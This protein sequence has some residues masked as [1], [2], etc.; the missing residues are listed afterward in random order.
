M[1]WSPSSSARRSL[2]AHGIALAGA[3]GARWSVI[4]PMRWARL[5]SLVVLA[6]ASVAHANPEP[7]ALYDARSAA[8]GGTGV[9]ASDGAAAIFHNPAALGLLDGLSASV[10]VTPMW[11]SVQAPFAP[12]GRP[13]EPI[14]E[15]N[16]TRTAPLFFLGVAGPL[17]KGLV[18]GL[19]AHVFSGIGST[20]PSVE[21]LDG[22][23]MDLAFAAGEATLPVAWRPCRG[24][25]LGAS[26]RL[27]YA[28]QRTDVFDPS[29]G[30]RA[31]QQLDGFAFPG[32]TLGVLW[33]PSP[34]IRLGATWRSASTID[35]SG[36][37]TLRWTGQDPVLAPTRSSWTIPHALRF[38][39]AWRLGSRWTVALESKVQ[40]H[41]N[42]NVESVFEVELP[43]LGHQVQRVPLRW[44]DTVAHLFGVE[45]CLPG[46]FAL[47]AGY[48]WSIS[49]APPTTANPFMP[50]PGSL[51]Q[52]TLG[53]GSR[54]GHFDAALALA[55]ALGSAQVR[56]PTPNG[57]A[58]HYAVRALFLSASLS[59]R[60]PQSDE[61][62]A[63][64]GP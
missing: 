23:R 3:F 18:A 9:A 20:F 48:G 13:A 36:Q 14:Q 34:S 31:E 11:A 17:A 26:L 22:E 38:G 1:Q 60:R 47:R 28:V 7:V 63:A 46:G 16:E 35:L 15:T 4:G 43:G 52:G 6:W 64:R 56:L 40:L 61:A 55:L 59:Y 58:G 45:H 57:A 41:R 62:G 29:L 8:M 49:S 39:S 25:S 2:H 19:G 51:H 54:W 44:R 50:P 21:A 53:L 37:T 5:W 30:A 12:P 24:L 32:V 27:L 33:R 42:A 10:T